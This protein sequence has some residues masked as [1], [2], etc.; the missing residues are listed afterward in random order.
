MKRLTRDLICT[1]IFVAL[2]APVH[3]E[4]QS[5]DFT[6]SIPADL[7]PTLEYAG[8]LQIRSLTIDG[9]RHLMTAPQTVLSPAEI[10]ER[11]KAFEANLREV[12]LSGKLELSDDMKKA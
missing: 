8:E 10:A 5:A 1:A 9:T 12:A 2:G 3:A 4:T 11:L 7:W 6:G